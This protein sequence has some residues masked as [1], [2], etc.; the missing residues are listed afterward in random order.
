MAVGLA[1]ARRVQQLE[2]LIDRDP[3]LAARDARPVAGG[4]RL[5]PRHFIDKCGLAHVRDAQYH[6]AH[7]PADL[8]LGGIRLDLVAQR[9]A[10][11][12]GK[13]V[14][15]L[16]AAAVGLE[17]GH[18]LPLKGCAPPRRCLRVSE[19]GAVEH[20]NTGL[21]AREAVNVRVA[22]R[23]RDARVEN[24]AHGIDLLHVL[25]D[26]ALGLRHMAREPLDIQLFKVLRHVISQ[27]RCS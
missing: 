19:I 7:R 4:G 10:H 3:L 1:D 11:R 17:H 22:A 24:F 5:A 20:D 16:A 12:A 2:A 18:A 14:D 15:A 6:D 8:P 27:L 21:V 23:R 13:A 25:L 9:C 26:H